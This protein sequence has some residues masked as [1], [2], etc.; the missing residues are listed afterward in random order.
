M[1]TFELPNTE[2]LDLWNMTYGDSVELFFNHTD[3]R[4]SLSYAG[5]VVHNESLF[6]NNTGEGEL[7]NK[8]VKLSMTFP[9]VRDDAFKRFVHTF[10]RYS[11]AGQVLT[12]RNTYDSFKFPIEYTDAT[13]DGVIAREYEGFIY[14]YKFSQVRE[15]LKRGVEVVSPYIPQVPTID[16]DQGKLRVP[17]VIDRA[18]ELSII[19]ISG[20]MVAKYAV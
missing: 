4:G 17:N 8:I 7:Y 3:V 12:M 2:K 14:D 13:T 6:F 11:D 16:D 10:V 15:S 5:N 20:K 18:Y 1:I 19:F 9:R